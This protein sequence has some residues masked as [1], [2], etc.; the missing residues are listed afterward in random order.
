MTPASN[1]VAAYARAGRLMTP[2]ALAVC[3]IV[4][5]GVRGVAAPAAA[6]VDRSAYLGAPVAMLGQQQRTIE[7]APS[8]LALRVGE[9]A[10]LQ[11][12][13][14]N[15]AGNPVA[16]ARLV[17]IS[18][19]PAA[20]SVT[21]DGAVEAHQAGDFTLVALLPATLEV[22]P[23]LVQPAAPGVRFEIPVRVTPSAL[24]RIEIE[25]MPAR[26]WAGSTLPI[27]TTAVSSTGRR[28]DVRPQLHVSDESIATIVAFG[29]IFEGSQKAHEFYRRDRPAL[30]PG[31]AA[32]V[33]TALRP[34][35]LTLTAEADGVRGSA[36]IEI[37]ENPVRALRLEASATSVRTGDVVHFRPIAAD[38]AGRPV[39]GPPV[40]YAIEARPD[41]SKPQ[42][43]G[44]GAP[45]QILPDGR[46]VAEQPGVHTVVGISGSAVARRSIRVTQRDVRRDV[47]FVGHARVNEYPTSDLWVW[48]GIDGHDYAVLGSWNGEGNAYFFDVTDPTDMRLIDTVQ[49]DART[50]NDV[51][52]SADGR[53]CVISREGASNRR[54]GLVIL[55]VSDP[56][57]V[58]VLSEFDDQLTGGVHNVFIHDDHV[59]AIN[60]GRRWDV[61]SIED[62][63]NPMRVARFEAEG[64]RRS[65]HDLW[66]R[67]GIAF[68]AGNSD[69]LIVVDVG[70]GGM[71]GTPSDPVEMGRMP[72]LTGWNHAVWPFRSASAGKFYVVGGDEAHPT[73]P[74]IPAPIISWEE[75]APS[76][77]MGWIHFVEFDDLDNPREVARY[78]V[79]DAGPHNLWIDWENEVMYVAYFNGGLR[80]VDVS[81]EL[82]GDL[83]RQGR[84]M[85]KF[86]SDD[87]LGF[88]PNAAF[89][90]GPQPHKGTVFFSDFHSGLWAIRLAE[91]E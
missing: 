78:R 67:D 26:V 15:A 62:P 60:N 19:A 58:Q 13:V 81:G 30:F 77:A 20:V 40:R 33:L 49:V 88:V 24:A 68:Q 43:L 42:S 8:Q 56:H 36:E 10:Q 50:V 65:V 47:E 84:E 48:E 28:T 74:R 75:R 34:G 63:A 69:G 87:L 29:A 52:V 35:T 73:N 55:D 61:I 25:G 31:D 23:D 80:V 76:R 54:N 83:Y 91:D 9:R 72:Q 82:V 14:R 85:A 6:D 38:A 64:S 3:V 59:Y 18:T 45:A 17:F 32:G 41:P 5:G 44:A 7:V 12:T 89:V 57:D 71:G 22:A 53:I 79:P 90:W 16:N 46:F 21:P 51:K 11:A 66:V 86:F 2:V 70:G 1:E 37:V 4:A 27:R 39:T